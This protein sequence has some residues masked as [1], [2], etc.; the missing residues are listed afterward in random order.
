MQMAQHFSSAGEHENALCLQRR[1]Q[2]RDAG[3]NWL[4]ILNSRPAK[5]S[6]EAP[7][8]PLQ[9]YAGRAVQRA[10]AV[11]GAQGRNPAHRMASAS[12]A[13]GESAFLQHERSKFLRV[14]LLASLRNG[15]SR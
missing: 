4:T 9:L 11:A 8:L 2:E 10:R 5:I 6:S 13:R 3:A 15:T 7:A 14:Q 12:A 1:R